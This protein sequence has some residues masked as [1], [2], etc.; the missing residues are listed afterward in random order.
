MTSENRKRELLVEIKEGVVN[1]EEDHVAAL[2]KQALDEGIDAKEILFD[3]LAAGMEKVGELFKSM[4]YFVP[5]VLMSADALYAGLEVLKPHISSDESN[6]RIKG[7]VLLGVVEGDVHNIGK[8]IVKMMFEAAGFQVHDLGVDVP[9]ERFV[10]EQA[11]INADI[12]C[13]SALMTTTLIGIKR[14]IEQLREQNPSIKIMVG[15]AP[16]TQEIAERW[17]ADAYG[18]DASS[19]VEEALKLIASLRKMEMDKYS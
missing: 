9:V 18:Q 10:E 12:V 2:C 11:K 14:A 16:V 6:E 4:E 15:G 3:G 17:G 5:E 1:F 13:I 7:K 8:N 19:A